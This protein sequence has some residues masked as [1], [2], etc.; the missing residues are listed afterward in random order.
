MPI[1]RAQVFFGHKKNGTLSLDLACPKCLTVII[2]TQLQF[3]LQ[4]NNK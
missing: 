1:R 2:A 4:L 3:N